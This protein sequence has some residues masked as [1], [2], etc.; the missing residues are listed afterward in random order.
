MHYLILGSIVIFTASF[1]QGITGFGFALIAVP[2]LS[3]FLPLKSIVPLVVLYS[4]ATNLFILK[5]TRNHIRLKDIRW[6][7]IFG[8][9]GIP[10]GVWILKTVDVNLLKT[11]AGFTI[12]ITAAAMIKGFQMKF[13]NEVISSGVAGFLSGVLNGSISMSGPPVVIFLANK[14]AEKDVFRANLSLYGIITNLITI[15][16][17]FISGLASPVIFKNFIFLFPGLVAGIMIG[18]L[19]VRKINETLFRKLILISII[20]MGLTIVITS[21]S[22]LI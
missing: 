9:I 21:L 5:E 13:R 1:I 10:F 7:I 15:A 19:T 6:V 22:K 11:L 14:D 12:A 17:F 20:A 3:Y 18:N 2:L 8:I 4:L 16:S